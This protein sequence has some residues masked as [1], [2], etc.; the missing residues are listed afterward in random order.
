VGT[1]VGGRV[2]GTVGGR[3]G[4]AVVGAAVV[5][6]AVGLGGFIVGGDVMAVDSCSLRLASWA[7]DTMLPGTLRAFTAFIVRYSGRQSSP[8]K[9][10]TPSITSF[11]ATLHW[12]VSAR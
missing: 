1:V 2:G 8:R 5:G 11:G 7:F 9:R 3:V 10:K 12:L 4:G 6:A